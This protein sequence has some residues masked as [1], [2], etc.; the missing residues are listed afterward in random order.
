M[1]RGKQG[2]SGR[3]ALEIRISKLEIRPRLRGNVNTHEEPKPRDPEG[4]P[5][6]GG[7]RGEGILPSLLYTRTAMACRNRDHSQPLEGKA[8]VRRAGEPKRRGVPQREQRP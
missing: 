6:R 4:S 2:E 8:G 5:G 3:P 1:T 7:L